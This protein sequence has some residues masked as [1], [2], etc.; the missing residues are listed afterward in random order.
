MSSPLVSV[1]TPVFNGADFLQES[2]ASVQA[3][4]YQN[5]EH[6]IV[7]NCST[8]G[9][10]EI[11]QRFADCD[12]RIRLIRAET[13]VDQLPNFN[14]LLR[15]MSPDSE[16]C[17]FVLADDWIFPTC[18]EEMVKVAQSGKN[19]GVVGSYSM[20]RNDIG[21][22]GL[23][24]SRHP[25]FDGAEACRRFLLTSSGFLGSP[26]CVMFRSDLVRARDPF[27]D[28]RVRLAA[29]VRVCLQLLLTS[30][31]GFS[32]QLL[33]FNRRDND[34]FWTREEPYGPVL[35][36]C[37]ILVREFGPAVLS[38]SEYLARLEQVESDYYRF[39]AFAVATRKGEE[40]WRY[41]RENLAPV[42][43]TIDPKRLRWET[44]RHY[45]DRLGN[46][47][48]SLENLWRNKWANR[49]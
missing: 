40:F 14:R 7:D 15:A 36:A 13:F 39:L 33:T 1:V 6:V 16:Y 3:Q 26:T 35:L 10:A 41:Q 8:D 20:Y 32:F 37:L 4:T 31:F 19:V 46:P 11:A 23:P 34:A 25:I 2:I 30:E 38:S 42:G 29:D 5:W 17:K 48:R 9:S 45:A 44:A 28:E 22:V 12:H 49:G 47:K 27:F 24:Y 21:H 43:L 18:I